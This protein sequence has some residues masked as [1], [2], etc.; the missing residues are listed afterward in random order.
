MD[1]GSAKDLRLF[2]YILWL[3]ERGLVFPSRTTVSR[4][5]PV[6]TKQNIE[7]RTPSQ[8]LFVADA[9]LTREESAL[10]VR[11]QAAIGLSRECAPLLF[12][13]RPEAI[14]TAIAWA[15]PQ[16]VVLLGLEA[17]KKA[18]S[19]KVSYRQISGK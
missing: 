9:E 10:F 7:E 15:R 4:T 5:P 11:I 2:A 6:E 17:L 1:R 19:F 14:K 8:L 18:T 16:A 13:A 12:Q 3:E